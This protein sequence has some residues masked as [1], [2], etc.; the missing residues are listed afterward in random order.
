MKR[1][2]TLLLAVVT[3]TTAA[4][5]IELY[6]G[7]SAI[8]TGKKP[9]VLIIFDNS[10][11]MGTTEQIKEPYDPSKTYPAIGG[12]N[13]L[14]EKFIY[15]TKGS[16]ID[17]SSIVP[18]SPSE[19][20]R[21][22]DEIN[23]CETARERLAVVGYYTGHIREY[24]FQGN[25]GSWQEIPSNNGA[26]IEVIDCWDDIQLQNPKNA[27]KVKQNGS[28]ISLPDGYPVDGKGTKQ[29]PI[30]YTE[31]VG[32]SNTKFG[33]GEVVTLYTDNYLRWLH[34]TSI[35]NVNLS[36]ME[37]AKSTISNLILS[38]PSVDF[39][40]EIFNL[41]YPLDQR[42]G[43]RIVAGI[44]EMSDTN[45]DN[46][47]NIIDNLNAQT[48]TPLCE[49][50]YEARR[51][52]G[53]LSVDFGNDD[54][55]FSNWYHAN[56]PPRDT[57]IEN[58][59]TYISPYSG[60]SNE[61]YIILITDGVPTMDNRADSY[62]QGLPDI[63][64]PF[65]ING[66][67][68]YLA[69]LAGWMHS[70]D[71]NSQLDGDQIATLFTIGFGE[72]AVNDAGEL[73][74][75]A[76]DNGG[77]KYYPA[78]DPSKLLSSLQSAIS[79]ILRVNATFVAPS[80]ASNNFDRTET[81]DSVYYA[82]FLPD[83]GPRWQ[84]NL[85]KLKVLNGKQVDRTSA[86]AIDND[87]N[88]AASAKT[89]WSSSAQPDGNDVTK[90]GVAEMLRAKTN[91][92]IYSD[93]GGVTGSLV[94]FTLTA[95]QNFFGGATQLAN[96]MNIS[97]ADIADYIA[98]AQGQDIDD[99]DQDG[100]T[101]ENRFDIFGDPLHSK[102][103]VIN[104]G[105]S[106]AN[107]D[108][109]IIVGTNAGALHMFDDNGDTVD[110]SWAFMPREF[111]KQYKELRNNFPSSPKVYGV[112]GSASAYILDK[113][114]DGTVSASA[115]DKAWIFFGLRRGGSSYYAIDVSNPDSP[116]LM[117]HIDSS[118]PGFS[119][120]GYSWSKPKVAYSALNIASSTAKPVLFIGGG[121]SINK[122]ADGVGTPDSVGRAVYMLDAES[123][124]LLWSLTPASNSSTNTH[125]A[126]INDSV[127]SSIAVMDSDSDGLADRLYFGDTGGNVWR[128]DMPSDDPNSSS[129]P[130][131]VIQLASL[132]GTTDL[133]DR[134]FFSE[135]AI[136]RTLITKTLQSTTTDADGNTHT[137]ISR[138]EV[139]YDAILIGSGDRTSPA[140]TSTDDKFFMIK[141][142]NITTQS[143]TA[144]TSPS[145][146]T[147]SDLYDYTDNPFGQTMSDAQ[148]QTLELAVSAKSGWFVDFVAP[149]EKSV[150]PATAIAGVAY[151][152]SFK[153]AASVTTNSCTLNTGGGTLY[154]I[155]LAL[156][157]TVY[158]W[159]T[160]DVGD[161]VPDTPTV[162]I[163]P[164]IS[165]PS[166]LLFVGVGK[167]DGDGTLT[168]CES[169]NCDPNDP[170]TGISLET[171][172]TYLYV[173]E[174]E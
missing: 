32:D 137:V 158:S 19:Q 151:F 10:G 75:A 68:N 166:K 154:A 139:P 118:T 143:F 1:I 42:D 83:R 31:N 144:G 58:H 87:G 102:P 46:L 161:R 82:M 24:A 105:G 123:G 163:P 28:L 15:Y 79:E 147:L 173:K 53:A 14:S 71:L 44:R 100:N 162:I 5:D 67:T 168:L 124:N 80:I 13:S 20:R 97:E 90:G 122:D 169:G 130:W 140:D 121:Y 74:R 78:D 50:L 60:C 43:G 171:M 18:D 120:L 150:S 113:N 103:L 30:Y 125:F 134:R 47:L 85:K 155:D 157:T 89:F 61:V 135:P 98:W 128:V 117:W 141:D 116:S 64:A 16:G 2:L 148:R 142:P 94:D 167:G 36:R 62:I 55:N 145:V 119:E 174:D 39:G 73:L 40:L 41:D 34:S 127:P 29:A 77:G 7:N 152:N 129:S 86:P 101:T 57:S 164:A 6:V 35:N 76:A 104:Y 66:S 112:D 111:F 70:H 51:Y 22:L 63:G 110:E 11:S 153:P 48:N 27:G 126:G 72:D 146:V 114:G 56:R 93:I 12:D 81:L 88:I 52:L 25:S 33:T 4:E 49:S 45:R 99:V 159:R 156:G 23:S 107:Q 108:I 109:R 38:A 91:R 138:Q 65:S 165:G 160:L 132:G 54:S 95:A 59:S 106:A 37:I 170:N 17:A 8:K 21:F 69:A 131:T 92:K 9:Q 149:G 26:N 172:R 115:G 136:V 96:E 84:G 3:I 133:D